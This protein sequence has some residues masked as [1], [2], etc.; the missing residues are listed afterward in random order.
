MTT[1]KT[2]RTHYSGLVGTFDKQYSG[3][4]QEC[5]EYQRERIA[6]FLEDNGV[7]KAATH[8]RL[9]DLGGGTGVD[10]Q[11]LRGQL[12]LTSDALVVDPCLEMIEL[13]SN[14]LGCFLNVSKHSKTM[15]QRMVGVKG[16]CCKAQDWCERVEEVFLYNRVLCKA[17]I[18]HFSKPVLHTM[19]TS[20]YKNLPPNSVRHAVTKTPLKS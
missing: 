7:S 6:H 8:I 2:L 15:T 10:A 17:A 18:H 9:V 1:S 13:A 11:W 20:L 14:H 19:F 12:N 4:L 16:I 3:T 5:E